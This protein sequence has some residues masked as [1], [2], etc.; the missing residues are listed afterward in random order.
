MWDNTI[1]TDK[2]IELLKNALNGGTINVTA[3]KAEL[4]KSM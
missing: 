4:E 1:I 3:I 2:G